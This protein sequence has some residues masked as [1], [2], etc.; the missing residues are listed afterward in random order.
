M[1]SFNGNNNDV[2]GGNSTHGFGGV[3]SYQDAT[4][5]ASGYGGGGAGLYYGIVGT[6]LVRDGT[7]GIVI[8]EEYA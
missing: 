3:K 5:T 4:S 2:R 7:G 8:V 1:S 6:S